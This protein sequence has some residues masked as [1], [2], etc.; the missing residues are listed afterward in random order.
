[1]FLQDGDWKSWFNATFYK[2]E[3]TWSES[4]CKRF[5][6]SSVLVTQAKLVQ[7]PGLAGQLLKIKV[8]HYYY[9][10]TFIPSTW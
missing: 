8:Q 6:N 4:D 1:M 2:K 3:L 10:F 9:D 7:T 5:E